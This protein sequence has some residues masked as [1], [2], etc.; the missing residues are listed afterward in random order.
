[1]LGAQVLTGA[2][3]CL[4]VITANAKV[5]CVAQVLLPLAIWLGLQP[6]LEQ[7]QG[8]LMWEWETLKEVIAGWIMI[9]VTLGTFGS[10]SQKGLEFVGLWEGLHHLRNIHIKMAL[11]IN[12][13][14]IVESMKLTKQSGRF[15]GW[16]KS[17]V[18]CLSSLV[19]PTCSRLHVRNTCCV[20]VWSCCFIPSCL[21]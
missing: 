2:P 11:D 6:V 18:L 3:W 14:R 1:M 10:L 15:H 13:K 16:E 17:P 5:E 8:S 19:D 4:S 7:P 21:Q 9:R 12:P 20:C